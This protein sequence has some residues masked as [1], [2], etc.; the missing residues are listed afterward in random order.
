MKI[1]SILLTGVIILAAASSLQAGDVIL[2][3][4]SQ[5]AGKL[6]FSS[7]TEIPEHL[8]QGEWGSTFGVRFSSGHVIGFEQNFGYSPKFAKEDVKA[9]QTDSNLLLQIPG[10]VAPY[11]TAGI[12]LIV[13]WGKDFPDDL[14]LEEIAAAAF[15]IGSKFSV[16]YGGGIKLRRIAGPLGF[17]V[18]L[19]GYT[20]PN[21]R[22]GALNFIRISLGAV[23]SW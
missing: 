10:N 11:A 9:F 20:V 18:D 23:F 21:A 17:N 12:G 15:N 14:D 3:G 8:L 5:K 2:Y 4:S 13:T 22:D 6:K 1:P 19:R 7:V 16:N